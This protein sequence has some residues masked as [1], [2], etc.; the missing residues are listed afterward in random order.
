MINPLLLLTWRPLPASVMVAVA[1]PEVLMVP[2]A[3]FTWATSGSDTL[4]RHCTVPAGPMAG[5]LMGALS[6][7]PAW[8]VMLVGL[9]GR[10][11]LGLYT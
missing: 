8:M 9:S 2:E 11:V 1:V 5:Q 6:P 10:E 7:P 3:R 4:N